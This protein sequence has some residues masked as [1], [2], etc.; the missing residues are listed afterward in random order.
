MSESPIVAGLIEWAV[1]TSNK[2]FGPVLTTC[3]ISSTALGIVG[4]ASCG[5]PFVPPVGKVA[6]SLGIL[7]IIVAMAGMILAWP[8]GGNTRML[9]LIFGMLLLGL[10]SVAIWVGQLGKHLFD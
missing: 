10:N 5:I 1:K 6:I 2:R 8:R 4:V 9:F 7:G 3:L